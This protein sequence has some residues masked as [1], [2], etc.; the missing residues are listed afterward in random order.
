[1]DSNRSWNSGT[2]TMRQWNAFR[3]R[4]PQAKLVCIDIQPY[5]HTQAQERPDILNIG[6]FSDRVFKL[7][8]EF[9]KGKLTAEHW[10]SVIEKVEI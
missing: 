2:A 7:I 10:V 9:A 3:E 4:N 1:M 8:S 6:G 5:A